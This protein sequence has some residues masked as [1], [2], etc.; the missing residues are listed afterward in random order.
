MQV[1]AGG[2]LATNAHRT[3]G[4]QPVHP[5]PFTASL[6]E[7]PPPPSSSRQDLK[8]RKKEKNAVLLFVL[9]FFLFLP[10]SLLPAASIAGLQRDRDSLVEIMKSNFGNRRALHAAVRRGRRALPAEKR[11]NKSPAMPERC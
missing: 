9:L 10:S 3:P 8:Q 5:L 1:P 4:V 11:R 7:P 2:S 6:A